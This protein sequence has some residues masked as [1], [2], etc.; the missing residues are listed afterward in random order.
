MKCE[1]CHRNT[2]T[3]AIREDKDGKPCELFVCDEC[4]HEKKKPVDSLS[5]ADI[6]FSLEPPPGTNPQGA[7]GVLGKVQ[8]D[9]L[10]F[11]T[12][13][14]EPHTPAV[15]PACGM[16]RD[17]LR[18]HRRYGCTACYDN[19]EDETRTFI[20]ELQ[21]GDAHVGRKPVAAELRSRLDG[22][23]SELETAVANQKFTK[24]AELRDAILRI[25]RSMPKR[26]E[27]PD[28]QA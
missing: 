15:C 21:F 7:L 2:A 28:G 22:L 9:A 19:F 23:K 27:S 4:A 17:T 12:G 16:T 24:A 18:E 1:R 3:Q 5:L 14:V 11:Q 13:A 25:E 8:E 20:H 10:P 6:L 26:G